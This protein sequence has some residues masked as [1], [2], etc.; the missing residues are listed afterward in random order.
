[1]FEAAP[2][3]ALP[4]NVDDTLGNQLIASYFKLEIYTDLNSTHFGTGEPEVVRRG[5]LQRERAL[6]SRLTL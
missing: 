2:T 5:P 6:G 4:H 1:M 3:R